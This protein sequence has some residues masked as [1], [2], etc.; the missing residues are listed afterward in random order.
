MPSLGLAMS[1]ARLIA[2]TDG[3]QIVLPTRFP[4]FGNA[5]YGQ[6]ARAVRSEDAQ[7]ERVRV[8]H[9]AFVHQAGLTGGSGCKEIRS[10]D[11][12]L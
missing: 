7:F 5:R 10:R 2:K 11:R 1:I 12:R 8:G 3:V 4:P 9:R 6:T